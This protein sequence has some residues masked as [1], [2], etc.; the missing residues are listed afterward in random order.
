M[1]GQKSEVFEFVFKACVFLCNLF[2]E[3]KK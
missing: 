2:N 3:H 1:L